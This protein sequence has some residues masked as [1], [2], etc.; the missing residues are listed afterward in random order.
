[1]VKFGDTAGEWTVQAWVGTFRIWICPRSGGWTEN[2]E[3]HGM[4]DPESQPSIGMGTCSWE[5]K[6][7]ETKQ[8]GQ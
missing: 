2:V 3:T 6:L 8:A 5:T 4:K 1:M 7:D